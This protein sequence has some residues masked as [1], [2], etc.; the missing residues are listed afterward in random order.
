MKKGLLLINLGTPDSPETSH[1]RRFLKEFLSDKR[2]IDLAAWL[3]YPLV[4]GTILPFRPKQTAK[5]YQAIWTKEG[6]PLLLNSLS[7]KNKVQAHLGLGWQVGLGMRYG[8]PSLKDSLHQ[9]AACSHLT[10]LPLFPQYSSAATGSALEKVLRLI[11][12]QNVLPSIKVIRDFY[13][14]QG[15]ISAQAALIQPQLANHD[16]LLLSYHGLPEGHLKK[17]GCPS[18]CTSECGLINE[19]TQACYRTQ[20]FATTRALANKLALSEGRYGMSFQSRLGKIPWIKPYT[21]EFLPELIKKGVKRLAIVCP[22]FTADC[23]ETLEEIGLRAKEQWLQLGGQQ[24]TLIPCVNDS[25][26]WVEGLVKLIER[27]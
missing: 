2:V 21:D 12:S 13:E 16:Y 15:F 23:L 19:T 3:R 9:F 24:L 11:A 26:L 17:A 27:P 6:S 4:Y 20:C 5:A 10:I 14:D 25:D 1:V 22:S 8:K 18:I 7:L